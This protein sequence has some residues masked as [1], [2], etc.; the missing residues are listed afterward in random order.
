[1][2]GEERNWGKGTRSTARGQNSPSYYLNRRQEMRKRDV[3]EKG[4]SA[5]EEEQSAQALA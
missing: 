2:A 3:T 4:K 5:K 1:V